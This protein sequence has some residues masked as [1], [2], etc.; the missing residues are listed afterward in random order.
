MNKGAGAYSPGIWKVVLV[1]LL[2][3][4]A[5]SIPLYIANGWI[6]PYYMKV[7][8]YGAKPILSLFG[9]ELTIASALSVTEELSLNP[10]VFLSLVFAVPRIVW[11]QRLRAAAWGFI[12]LVAVNIIVLILLATSRSLDSESLWTGTEFLYLTINFFLPLL[13]AFLLLPL[14]SLR[15]FLDEKRDVPQDVS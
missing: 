4:L 7:L 12:I 13:L 8:A 9:V 5:I 3:F 6:G 2:R 15:E 14:R 11:A 10:V 1:F